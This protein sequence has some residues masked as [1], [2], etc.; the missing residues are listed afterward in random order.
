MVS[1]QQATSIV[2]SEF[3]DGTIES[4][5]SY[6]NLFV[7]KVFTKDSQEGQ[8][9]PFF[10][11]DKTTGE[12]RDFSIITDGDITEITDLFFKAEGRGS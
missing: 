12:L 6:K 9:D 4:Y 1:S 7:F 2:K 3:P 8:M 10:S 5:I 11:V